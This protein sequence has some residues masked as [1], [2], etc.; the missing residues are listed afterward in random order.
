MQ[1]TQLLFAPYNRKG[2]VPTKEQLDAGDYEWDFP[3]ERTF[4]VDNE[5][6]YIKE[7]NT[8]PLKH[9]DMSIVGMGIRPES[10]TAGGMAQADA[11]VI[12]KLA[13]KD[14]S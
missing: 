5:S 8:K 9:R 7:G 3:K 10:F 13:G 11:I 6:G 2:K 12:K 14:P 1:L 4:R